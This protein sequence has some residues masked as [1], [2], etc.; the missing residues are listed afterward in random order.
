MKFSRWKK[1][2][3]GD[4]VCECGHF[5]IIAPASA[6][7]ERWLLHGNQNYIVREHYATLGRC[8]TLK[9]AKAL[10]QQ[11]AQ[12]REQVFPYFLERARYEKRRARKH[13]ISLPECLA[14]RARP[15]L[16]CDVETEAERLYHYVKYRAFM[17]TPDGAPIA[18]DMRRDWEAMVAGTYVQY[19]K[20]KPVAERIL[21]GEI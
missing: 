12:W 7:R 14:E 2:Q 11:H 3:S 8:A 18:P 13:Y 10:A 5:A 6:N 17:T 4:R 15:L 1:T 20:Q 9:E 16:H 19:W 21:C